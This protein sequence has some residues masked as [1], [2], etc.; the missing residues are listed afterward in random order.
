MTCPVGDEGP[1]PAGVWTPTFD[2]MSVEGSVSSKEI[3]SYYDG[4]SREVQERVG[5]NRRHRHIIRRFKATGL[6]RDH[7]VLEIGCGIG[8]LTGLIAPLV[9][10]GGVLG[11]DISPNAI[12]LARKRSE[13]RRNVTLA[14]DDMS[15]FVSDRRFDRILLPDV[16]EHIPEETH[17]RLFLTMVEHLAPSGLICIHIPDPDWIRWAARNA[18]SALQIVDQPLDILAMAKR[19]ARVGLELKCFERYSIWT[20]EPDYN[21]IVFGAP[22]VEPVRTPYGKI[23]QFWEEFTSRVRS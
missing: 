11:V 9:S 1:G 19:S 16:L 7:H 17:D 4:H 15:A 6:E 20:K 14:V 8:Q 12:A 10:D 22:T 18:Q 13:G 5:I 2:D 3:E 21:W 23:R